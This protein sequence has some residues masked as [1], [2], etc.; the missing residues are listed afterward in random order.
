MRVVFIL[1]DSTCRR[2][3]KAYGSAHPAITPNLDRLAEMGCVFDNHWVGS[4]PC[5]PARRDIMTGRVNF[6]EKPW[7]AIEPFDQTLP[8]LLRTVNAHTHIVT[9]H[10]HYLRKGGEDY[11]G[12]FTSYEIIRGQE[13]DTL[14]LPAGPDGL[15]RQERPAGLKG[16]YDLAHDE[17]YKKFTDETQYPTP[18]T[19]QHAA[20][21][22]ERN[23]DADNFLLWTECFDPHEPFDVP[24]QYL[25]LYRDEDDY[26]GGD[27][28]WPKYAPNTFNEQETRHLA[29]L[30]KAQLTM[31]D[32]YIGR[33]FDVLDRNDMWKD[34]MV[35]YTTDHGFMLGEHGYMAK[36]YMPA[37]NEV[38]NIPL[39]I[40]HPQATVKR[41]AGIT[42]NVDILPT[43]CHQFGVD[44]GIMQYPLH[45]MDL[46]PCLTGEQDAAHTEILFGNFG[47]SVNYYD[48]QYVYMRAAAREDNKPLNVYTAMPTTHDRTFGWGTVEQADYARIGM[49][50]NYAGYPV[51][52]IPAEVI[53][54]KGGSSGFDVRSEYNAE[55][56]LFD[57]R[58]DY[59]EEHPLHDAALEARCVEGLKRCMAA[60]QAPEEQYERLG[61]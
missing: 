48:G 23:K 56:L 12:S 55:N 60:R 58:E 1:T 57:I 17:T 16:G 32:H 49:A 54:M 29:C 46:T 31:T 18:V 34:T 13:H 5:M 45:G 39:I 44:R 43:V 22:L 25:D 15:I 6:L 28:Y 50:R 11:L 4:A 3:L 61:L 41:F 47:K 53:G 26:E 52:K 7:G 20:E 27:L 40:W 8:G 33:V 21:W 19:L 9:D 14:N 59:A 35:I 36:N 37:Y 24:G 42:Q 2:Y 51:L 38:F 30:Y 10:Y